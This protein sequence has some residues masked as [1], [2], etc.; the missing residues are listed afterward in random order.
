MKTVIILGSV[1]RKF[2]FL[3]MTWNLLDFLGS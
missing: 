1:M 3:Y 2:G